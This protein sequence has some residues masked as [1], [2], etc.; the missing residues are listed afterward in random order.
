MRQAVVDLA[1]VV[2]SLLAVL[3][4]AIGSLG[5]VRSRIR[6]V[7]R[8]TIGRALQS[9]EGVDATGRRALRRASVGRTALVRTAADEI[10]DLLGLFRDPAPFLVGGRPDACLD[11]VDASRLR[12]AYLRFA[13]SLDRRT[14]HPLSIRLAAVARQVAE[15]LQSDLDG[16]DAHVTE[17]TQRLTGRGFVLDL[18]RTPGPCDVTLTYRAA[19]HPEPAAV[20]PSPPV[21][22]GRSYDG[23]LP[24]LTDA[25]MERDVTNGR[26]RLHLAVA[27]TS[28]YQFRGVNQAR[29]ASLGETPDHLPA[30]G[31]LTLSCIPVDSEGNLLL[32]RRDLALEHRPGAVNSFATGNVDLRSRRRIAVDV[33]AAGVPDVTS[34]VVREMREETGTSVSLADVYVVGLSQVWS[35]QDRGTWVLSFSTQLAHPWREVA[36]T[37]RKGDPVEGSWE[38]GQ[39]L[40][41][42]DLPRALDDAAAVFNGLASQPDIVPHVLANVAAIAVSRGIP[43]DDLCAA[44]RAR[45]GQDDRDALQAAVHET[46]IARPL[47]G[48]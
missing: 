40:L 15:I 9:I 3:V 5:W 36:R 27:Q 44:I 7:W 8:R 29:L 41:V 48:R 11:D 4:L 37:F 13:A 1:T 33:D 30:T 2:A 10:S 32:T 21:P 42:L 25:R 22:V 12:D 19:T 31:L 23:L 16:V 39:H 38:V 47:E 24:W 28:Y 18:V 45:E 46:R 14:A 43:Q 20:A 26:A 6:T 34:A 17:P 35:H